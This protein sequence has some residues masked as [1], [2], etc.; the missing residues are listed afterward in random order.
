MASNSTPPAV[1][2]ASS[3]GRAATNRMGSALMAAANCAA[4]LICAL[5]STSYKMAALMPSMCKRLFRWL[6]SERVPRG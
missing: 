3:M 4:S 5:L 2:M 1:L 6:D